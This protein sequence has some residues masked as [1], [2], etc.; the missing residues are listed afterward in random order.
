MWF[1][2]SRRK[3]IVAQNFA[4][5]LVSNVSC[6]RECQKKRGLEENKTPLTPCLPPYHNGLYVVA[7]EEFFLLPHCYSQ[8][9]CES[10]ETLDSSK[11][12]ILFWCSCGVRRWS[13][14]CFCN[15]KFFSAKLCYPL[16]CIIVIPILAVWLTL[17][18]L[19]VYFLN[20]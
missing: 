10:S 20:T 13:R 12:L 3:N 19:W 5:P 16:P 6:K 9:S 1:C 4:C 15:F 7:P 2:R 11:R 17:G 8:P 14:R 18:I